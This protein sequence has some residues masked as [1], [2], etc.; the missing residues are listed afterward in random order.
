MVNVAAPA[1]AVFPRFR[2]RNLQRKYSLPVAGRCVLILI[3]WILFQT[4][5]KELQCLG[6]CL[7]LEGHQGQP[8]ESK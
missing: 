5:F 8:L 6:P 2:E 3:A 4:S 7:T 1:I